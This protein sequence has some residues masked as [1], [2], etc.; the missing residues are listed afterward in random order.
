MSL[1]VEEEVLPSMDVGELKKFWWK[2]SGEDSC[3]IVHSENEIQELDNY[4]QKYED[5]IY[6]ESLPDPGGE[7]IDIIVLKCKLTGDEH[8]FR[9]CGNRVN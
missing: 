7:M 2:N 8:R 9:Y 4:H 5:M 3:E 6:Y 1:Q